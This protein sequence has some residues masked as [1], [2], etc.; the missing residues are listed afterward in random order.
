MNWPA[1]PPP[2]QQAEARHSAYFQTVLA[3]YQANPTDSTRNAVTT[4]FENIWGGW[5]WAV[6]HR[7]ADLTHAYVAGLSRLLE[8]SYRFQ[9]LIDV[10]QTTL[11][12]RREQ[13][14]KTSPTPQPP[15]ANLQPV[16]LESGT[17]VDAGYDRLLAEAHYQVGH[18]TESEA[19][20]VQALN[21]LNQPM[22]FGLPKLTGGLA[23]ELGRQILHR[24]HIARPAV[25]RNPAQMA[26]VT[27]A[28]RAYERLGQIY[29]LADQ[30]ASA[31]YA[32]LK[33]LNLAENIPPSPELVRLYANME[34]AMGLVPF[35]LL[36]RLYGRLAAETATRL[37]QSQSLAWVLE[38]HSLYSLGLGHWAEV[39]RAA[40]QAIDISR[41]L[42]HHRRTEECQVM[43]AEQAY[44][45]G[46]FAEALTVWQEMYYSALQRGDIQVQ[47][48][49]LSGQSRNLLPQGQFEAAIPLLEQAL[50][51]P[52]EGFD[53]T[54][55]ISCYG[56]LAVARL[57]TG[58]HAQALSAARTGLELIT[59]RPSTTVT[60]MNGYVGIVETLVRLLYL[61]T[62][63]ADGVPPPVLLAEAQTALKLLR[64]FTR[65][66]PIGQPYLAL[67][68]GKLIQL[69]GKRQTRRA[70]KLWQDGLQ[71]ARLLEM[72]H[73]AAR[74]QAEHELAA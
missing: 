43:L 68:Y 38:V 54:T 30:T 35:H 31:I 53:R 18:L 69:G 15:H 60:V 47:K 29:F 74:L 57:E 16:N 23:V 26:A 65:L 3:Q 11:E 13:E 21:R 50:A 72:P 51:F 40:A 6:R 10:L 58:C 70:M 4:E 42:G 17:P 22:P 67:W 36:A 7:Q 71:T 2:R 24:L 45:R 52:V 20:F 64:R 46:H 48:W 62:A 33:G 49:S 32:A 61:E 56:G 37:D 19:C 63:A 1:T 27:E 9:E 44:H 59:A 12:N 73:L 34:L 66:F 55:N 28:V 8:E 41:Q 39:Q 25:T 14:A 5:Q